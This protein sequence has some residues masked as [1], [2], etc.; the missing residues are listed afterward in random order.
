MVGLPSLEKK[1]FFKEKEKEKENKFFFLRVSIPRSGKFSTKI[2][3]Y[4]YLVSN[5]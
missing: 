5:I 4:S 3:R 1:I 2:F